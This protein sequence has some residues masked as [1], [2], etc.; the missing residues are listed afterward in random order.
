[1]AVSQDTRNPSVASKRSRPISD[2]IGDLEADLGKL[3]DLVA[4]I[5]D[6]N[7]T[8]IGYAENGTPAHVYAERI[9]SLAVITRDLLEDAGAAAEACGERFKRERATA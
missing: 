2:D 5:I 3:S 9:T 8:V 6:L 7:D 4:A 1:M